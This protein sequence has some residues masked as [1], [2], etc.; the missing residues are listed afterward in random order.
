MISISAFVFQHVVCACLR[1][2][3]AEQG[4][5]C[6]PF[7][8]DPQVANNGLEDVHATP[9]QGQ[10]LLPRPIHQFR[11]AT[12]F[13]STPSAATVAGLLVAGLGAAY[14]YTQ[15][16]TPKDTHT[17][18]HTT[19]P[20]EDGDSHATNEAGYAS[21]AARKG[22]KKRRG[23]GAGV[24]VG[25]DEGQGESKDK[26]EGGLAIVPQVIPGNFEGVGA[27]AGTHVGPHEASPSGTVSKRGN[28]G[29]TRTK[30]NKNKKQGKG[31]DEDED[32]EE[33]SETG[34]EVGV[35]VG[36]GRAATH[37]P[38][39][40]DST[41]A[42]VSLS[43]SVSASALASSRATRKGNLRAA[44]TRLAPPSQ[45]REI[46]P[47]L[48]FDTD[49]SWTHVDHSHLKSSRSTDGRTRGLADAMD[50]T[51]SDLASTASNSPVAERMDGVATDIRGARAD[52]VERTLA[53]KPKQ[54]TVDEYVS[55]QRSRHFSSLFFFRQLFRFISSFLACPPSHF[56]W[57]FSCMSLEMVWVLILDLFS[58]FG[59]LAYWKSPMSLRWHASCRSSL[60]RTR[61][62]S[63]ASHGRTMERSSKRACSSTMRIKK[64]K[65]N[66]ASSRV[67]TVPVILF[68]LLP[69][70]F[71]PTQQIKKYDQAPHR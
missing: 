71:S 15:L 43:P 65:G 49:S 21:G 14:A 1:V 62:P 70:H 18:A 63:Q 20:S 8:L 5:Y 34:K 22:R 3:A 66:G 27:D 39:S 69:L 52:L 44:S 9:L 29:K 67:E 12:D 23:K 32:E 45:P 13:L 64:T 47:S 57:L 33:G 31:K 42:S 40:S 6:A 58:P 24:D 30:K 55:F 46:R 19:G 2:A 41:D 59:L 37:R 36:V 56:Q 16:G 11:M 4:H 25:K 51:S 53:E 10:G 54:T 26:G 68:L 28:G 17:H 35:G 61:L 7:F 38:H 60:L 48:S 50:V